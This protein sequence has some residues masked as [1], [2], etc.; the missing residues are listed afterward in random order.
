MI[1]LHALVEG[2]T[3]EAFF[4]R[5]IAKHL[6]TM[7]IQADVRLI[8]Q[9][10][11]SNSRIYKGGWNSYAAASRDLS[12]WMREDT[13]AWFT[14]MVDLYAIPK[15]FP[16]LANS[17]G[18]QSPYER[19][20][21]LEE[22]WKIAVCTDKIWRFMPYIQL[23]EFEALLLADPQQ[24][25]WE[26]LEH[27][28]AIEKLVKMVGGVNPELIDD[29]AQT[30]PSKRIIKEIPEYEDRKASAGPVVADKI[31]LEALRARC[32]HFDQWLTA[33]EALAQ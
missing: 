8:N 19:V 25:D 11:S 20:N 6:A 22:A 14:T 2:Q 32:Q 12:R 23:H 1:R 26:F 7:D 3:E 17:A 18:I 29:G 4:N 16:N 15:D 33:L 13:G 9:R 24:L 28:K 30:A 10:M 27:E 31:G 21:F 5:A